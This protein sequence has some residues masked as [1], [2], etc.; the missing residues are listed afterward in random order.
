MPTAQTEDIFSKRKEGD[1]DNVCISHEGCQS[2]GLK[3]IHGAKGTQNDKSSFFREC[4]DQVKGKCDGSEYRTD[5]GLAT[6][7]YFLKGKCA[8]LFRVIVLTQLNKSSRVRNA[9]QLTESH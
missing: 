1:Q 9:T 6:T 2:K 8:Q 3:N 5:C 4:S 7:T